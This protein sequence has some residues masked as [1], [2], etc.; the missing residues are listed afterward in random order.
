[1][2]DADTDSDDAEP[3]STETFADRGDIPENAH[4]TACGAVI[5]DDGETIGE[6]GDVDT[7]VGFHPDDSANTDD[8]GSRSP[9]GDPKGSDG[10]DT[11]PAGETEG[12]R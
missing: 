10:E 12:S 3:N 11:T 5:D 2:S 7:P 8:E 4:I 9:D 6:V 1:M